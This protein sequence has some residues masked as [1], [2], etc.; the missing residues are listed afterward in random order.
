MHLI[1]F[2]CRRTP[3]I[4]PLEL[5]SRVAPKF[6]ARQEFEFSA[7]LAA[8]MAILTVSHGLHGVNTTVKEEIE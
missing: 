4:G 6:D 3:R 5:I 8:E 2:N 1:F 7:E